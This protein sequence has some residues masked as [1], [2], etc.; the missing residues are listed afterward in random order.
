MVEIVERGLPRSDNKFQARC[1]DC[2]TLFNFKRAEA[3]FVPDQRDGDA[4]KIK[5]PV[6]GVMVWRAA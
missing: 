3:E 4:L 5:C 2:Q 1:P 6:C